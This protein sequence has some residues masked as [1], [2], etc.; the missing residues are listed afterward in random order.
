[1]KLSH[2]ICWTMLMF[3]TVSAQE[4]PT[5]TL[6]EEATVETTDAAAEEQPAAAESA[7][8]RTQWL[9]FTAAWCRPCAAAKDD[10]VAWLR[11]G[12]W[13]VDDGESAHVRLIDGDV[14]PKLVER[15]QITQYPTFLLLQ[16]GNVLFRHAGYPGREALVSRYQQAVT[17]SSTAVGAVSVGTLKGQRENIA[18]LIHALRPALS[19]GGT[20]TVRLDR[21]ESKTAALPL[22]ESLAVRFEDP[23]VMNFTLRNERLICRFEEPLPRARLSWGVPWEQ[24]VTAVTI[25]VAEIVLELPRAPDVRLRVEP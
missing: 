9:M 1:M 18:Q 17:S 16:D 11:C 14:H 23:L 12:G 4:R 24:S 25:S 21:T 6:S 15:H 13:I 20:L 19:G 22:G 2:A 3:G 10:F 8:R 5:F 7:T